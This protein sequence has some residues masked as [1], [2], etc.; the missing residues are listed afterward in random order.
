MNLLFRTYNK[1]IPLAVVSNKTLKVGDI[2][3]IH[4]KKYYI[5]C[6]PNTIS[7]SG[8]KNKF[9]YCVKTTENAVVTNK[10]KN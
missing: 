4:K 3:E 5:N 1:I 10:V 8:K 7:P 6:E 2:V 9:Y